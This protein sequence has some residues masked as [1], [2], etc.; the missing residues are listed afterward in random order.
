MDLYLAIEQ[1]ILNRQYQVVTVA[2]QQRCRV[3]QSDDGHQAVYRG[4]V[5][6]TVPGTSEEVN[7]RKFAIRLDVQTDPYLAMPAI[8][9]S[10]WRIVEVRN[11]GLAYQCF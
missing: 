9:T 7:V 2:T 1:L 11:K 4:V 3:W 8:L 5:Q 6:Y 10:Q